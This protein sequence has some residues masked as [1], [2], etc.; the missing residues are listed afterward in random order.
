MYF[1]HYQKVLGIV[2]KTTGSEFDNIEVGRKDCG[3]TG[4]MVKYQTDDSWEEFTWQLQRLNCLPAQ[5]GLH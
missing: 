2:R 5:A 1:A 4:Y 3:Q